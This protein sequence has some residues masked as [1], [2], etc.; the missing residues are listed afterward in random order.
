[1]GLH[2]EEIEVVK[3]A[4]LLHDIGR[5]GIDESI[6]VKTDALTQKEYEALK[7]HP[8]IGANILKDVNFL[9]KEI[10]LVLYHHERYDGN[11]Y[12]QGLKGREI[13]LGAR[14]LAVADAYDAMTTDRGFKRRM[15]EQEAIEELKQGKQTQFSPEIVDAFIRV[16]QGRN[17]SGKSR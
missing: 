2:L 10:P 11:G 5:I 15:S 13:P 8:V 6:L 17:R 12:P 16:L 1:M 3:Y 7:K 9:E 4:G 14:I